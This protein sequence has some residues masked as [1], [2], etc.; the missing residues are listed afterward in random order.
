MASNLYRDTTMDPAKARHLQ[1]IWDG[2][3]KK[4]AK[5]TDFQEDELQVLCLIFHKICETHGEQGG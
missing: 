5:H 2:R 3:I 1:V 4:L